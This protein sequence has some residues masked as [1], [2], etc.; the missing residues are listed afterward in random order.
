[1]RGE[2]STL[3]ATGVR[4][5]ITP[6]Y[7]G[8]TGAAG[9]RGRGAA[10][11]P[12][13]CGENLQGDFEE[14]AS[15]GSPPRMR[16]ELQCSGSGMSPLRITPAYAGRTALAVHGLRPDW[17]H[18]RVCGE[19]TGTDQ[20]P[21]VSNGSPPRMRGERSPLDHRHRPARITP[22]YAGRTCRRSSRPWRRWD[23]PRV[24]GE[25]S[26]WCGGCGGDEG[27]PPR[28]RGE[29]PSERVE[30]GTWRITP[31]YA[32]RT[33]FSWPAWWSVWDHPRVC[34]ENS[35]C[36]RRSA[37]SARIT[38]AYAGR[39]C[40]AR[41]AQSWRRDHPRVCGENDKETQVIWTL[42]GSPPRMRGEPSS[43]LSEAGSR[44]DHP[45]VCGENS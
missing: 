8:R 10:D 41:C 38:P 2:R 1:M 32:G 26:C 40:P 12:R 23:H 35:G 30:G 5:R 21:V 31:A 43:L 22:A 42:A 16:G 11:H 37:A 19:N 13:V 27:S 34:G 28:M 29:Q 9:P 18:P 33:S 36:R 25:N 4:P 15:V 14:Q 24:C 44:T 7:A 20:A 3:H 39:T 6:A 17:D 45:R